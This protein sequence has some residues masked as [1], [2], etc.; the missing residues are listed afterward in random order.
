SNRWRTIMSDAAVSL[1][2]PVAAARPLA[3]SPASSP[4]LG[5]GA[6]LIW[7]VAGI[8]AIMIFWLT[9]HLPLQWM[10]LSSYPVLVLISFGHVAALASVLAALWFHRLPLR[11]YLA[12]PALRWRHVRR[13]LLLGVVGYLVLVVS[14][15]LAGLVYSAVS[16]SSVP[17]FMPSPMDGL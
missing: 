4:R 15:N 12:L 5:L 6:T 7:G 10:R 16:G 9:D 11:E 14:S 3:G 8:A 17:A 13:G 1:G 2:H